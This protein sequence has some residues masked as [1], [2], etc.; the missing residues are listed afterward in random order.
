MNASLTT[1]LILAGI[2][3]ANLA[4]AQPAP[5]D[6][7]K[8][9]DKFLSAHT[10]QRVVTKEM[11]LEYLQ[12]LPADYEKKKDEKW[13][14]ILFL[15]GAGER[16]TNVW[17]VNIHGPSKYI[18]QNPDFPFIMI[19]P[20]CPAGQRW[21]NESLL[22]L[23]DDA[24]KTY[25]VDTSRIYLTGLSMGGYGTWSLGMAHPEKFAAIAPVCGGGQRVDV[26]LTARKLNGPENLE[27]LQT[28]GVWAFHGAKDTVVP[29]EESER[30]IGF[31]KDAK[32]QEVKFTVYPE[33]QHDS[34]TETYNNP[35]VYD[36]LLQHRRGKKE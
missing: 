36:W 29:L 27:A 24:V 12:F 33:A 20:L 23:L 6:A 19:S 1:A 17:R 4:S 7:A 31:L 34:W 9:Q 18:L 16:G 2:F 25:R 22:A 26:L 32:C 30:M 3:S 11:R 28:L 8:P 35:A 14:M 15:H 5:Q 13:P 21:E 10:F